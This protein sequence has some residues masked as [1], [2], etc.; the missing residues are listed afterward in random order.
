MNK[1]H[2]EEVHRTNF[3]LGKGHYFIQQPSE[4]DTGN[5]RIGI[6]HRV[7]DGAYDSESYITVPVEDIPALMDQIADYI[8]YPRYTSLLEMKSRLED[9]LREKERVAGPEDY[10]YLKLLR[11]ILEDDQNV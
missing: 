4:W 7:A 9:L 11:G 10:E 8:V 6:E 2:E 3:V 5:V 1:Q